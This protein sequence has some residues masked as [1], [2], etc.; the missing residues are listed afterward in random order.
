MS[1]VRF[2]EKCNNS[3]ENTSVPIIFFSNKY[4][5]S[6]I[7]NFFSGFIYGIKEEYWNDT[8]KC[9]YCE[10]ET[11]IIDITE[12]DFYNIFVATNGNRQVLEAMIDLKQKDIIEY[13]LKMGQ[14]RNQVEQQKSIQNQQAQVK[15]ESNVPKCPTCQSTNIRKIGAGE[16]AASVLGLGIFSKKINKTWKC[17]NC[18]HTW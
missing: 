12:K 5:N 2:C 1:K 14:F 13:E 18:G 4:D 6:T 17:N 9:P 3:K 8:N 16:R 10:N 11:T 15:Q 7:E